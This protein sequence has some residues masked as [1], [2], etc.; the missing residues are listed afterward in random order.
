M[1]FKSKDNKFLI[2]ALAAVNI[3]HKKTL[4]TFAMDRVLISIRN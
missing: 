1:Q 3:H 2:K 4:P